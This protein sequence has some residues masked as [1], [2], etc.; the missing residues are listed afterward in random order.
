MQPTQTLKPG[1][2]GTLFVWSKR[3]SH[4]L[5]A[6][7]TQ[8]IVGFSVSIPYTLAVAGSKLVSFSMY[9][10]FTCLVISGSLRLISVV[11]LSEEAG[12]Q[13]LGQDGVAIW[14]VRT[15]AV[16]LSG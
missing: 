3:K 9:S 2:S 7:W 15:V 11:K 1:G 4:H 5:L 14:R 8:I 16:T 10:I 6:A 12:I 13:C